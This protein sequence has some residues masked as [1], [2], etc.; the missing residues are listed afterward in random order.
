MGKIKLN[1]FD[2]PAIYLNEEPVVLPS[3]KAEALLFYL[4]VEG[5]STRDELVE[6]FWGDMDDERAKKNLRNTIYKIKKSFDFDIVF[7]PQKHLIM[8]NPAYEIDTDLVIDACDIEKAA[9]HYQNEF[10]NTFQFLKC[11]DRF[12]EWLN[13][14]RAYYKGLYYKKMTELIYEKMAG[15]ETKDVEF[16]VNLIISQDELDEEPYIILMKYYIN[17]GFYHKAIELYHKLAEVLERELSIEP[18]LT[19]QE[20]YKQVIAIQESKVIEE[21]LQKK[22]FFVGRI[23]E[24]HELMI[25][26]HG[27]VH[28]ENTKSMIVSGETGIGK[29]RLV[30]EFIDQV[31]DDVIIIRTQCYLAEKNYLLKPWNPVFLKI[32]EIASREKI[33]MPSQWEGVIAYT[34]PNHDSLINF[35]NIDLLSNMENLRFQII[36]EAITSSLSKISKN[37]KVLL[38]IDDLQWM[39]EMSLLLLNSLIIHCDHTQIMIIATKGEDSEDRIEK[40]ISQWGRY[41]LI[42]NIHLDRFER[43]EVEQFAKYYLND[44][45]NSKAI[46]DKIFSETSGN[47]F[48]VVEYLNCLKNCIG[49]EDNTACFGIT[50]NMENIIRNRFMQLSPEAKNIL[51]LCALFFDFVSLKMLK[52]LSAKNE[53]EIL[54]LVEELQ[55]K[56]IIKE[57]QTIDDLTEIKFEFTH[58][59]LREYINNQMSAS[60]KQIFHNKIA[61]LMIK[62]LKKDKSDRLMYSQLIYHYQNAGDLINALKYMVFNA[63]NYF[64]YDHEFFPIINQDYSL[65]KPVEVTNEFS[66]KCFMDIET[67]LKM[68]QK[69]YL[70]TNEVQTIHQE[71]FH[72]KGR[73]YI[74]IGK[75]K[76]GIQMIKKVIDDAF[77]TN[78]F[79]IAFKGYKQMIYYYRQ[80]DDTKNMRSF[81]EKGLEMAS[82]NKNKEQLGV[83]YRL[84][85]LCLIMGKQFGEAEDNLELSIKLFSELEKYNSKFVLN[86]AA[87]HNYI[88]DIRRITNDYPAA[89][90]CYKT[91]IEICDSKQL[92]Q[93]IYIFLTSAGVVSYEMNKFDDAKAYLKRSIEIYN[94]SSAIWG[95]AV[96]LGYY[97]LLLIQNLQYAEAAEY[98][99]NSYTYLR[100]MRS[101][102]ESEVINT[103]KSRIKA[104]S[105]QNK[106]IEKFFKYII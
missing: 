101:P 5:P 11:G 38:V 10:L 61:T 70:I 54:D 58:Q 53:I 48:F 39:D 81:I 3:R 93:G 104:A 52:D 68:V 47:T 35:R 24:M 64:D 13:Q 1:M 82:K 9:D 100:K 74:H 97:S 102:Q 73:Y 2:T 105:L 96:A 66:M 29:T 17:L 43:N 90:Q 18:G 37:K 41:N 78:S 79:E 36:E 71:Y 46:I 85:G 69:K 51:N 31:K 8:L 87:A 99:K 30:N 60:R 32:Y 76:E 57:I 27:F 98:L 88:G 42:R 80:I 25:N 77:K 67:M 40:Y 91:A 50:P 4:V 63:K 7:S 106:E 6:I 56:N 20:L 16:Y 95:R 103:I 45:Q 92:S 23:N 21:D 72:L 89:L 12:E 94:H 15:N 49:D 75:Y 65:D 59:K 14:K 62:N 22:H 34:N 33:K 86:I 83:L 44:K 84:K 19:M 28:N 55:N 26:F